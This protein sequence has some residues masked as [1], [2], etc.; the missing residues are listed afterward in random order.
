VYLLGVSDT[1]KLAVVTPVPS[2]Q[3]FEEQNLGGATG[4]AGG[5]TV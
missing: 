4:Q 3:N 1:R 5:A 2:A